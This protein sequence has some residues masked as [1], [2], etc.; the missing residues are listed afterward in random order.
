MPSNPVRLRNV[1]R[2]W[3]PRRWKGFTLIE[4]LVVIAI[5]AV[6][7]ALLLPAVQQARESA[8]RSQCK[9]NLKQ[10][11]LAFHNYHDVSRAFPIGTRFSMNSPNW[12]VGLL[13]YMDQ[14][15]LFNQLNFG[16]PFL[17]S[18]VYPPNS[19]LLST[20]VPLYECPSNAL[21]RRPSYTGEAD[22]TAGMAALDYVG[23][24][25]ASPDPAGRVTGSV[26]GGQTYGDYAR[27]GM[28]VNNESIKVSDCTDGLSATLMVAEQ[29]GQIGATTANGTHDLRSRYYGG[30]AGC[31]CNATGL[32]YNPL[33][34]WPCWSAGSSISLTGTGNLYGTG[35]TVVKYSSNART[36]TG[37][38]QYRYGANT[39]LTSSHTGGVH[40]LLGDGSVRF[41]SDNINLLTLQQLA[42]RDDGGIVGE[43]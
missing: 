4:L 35:I 42:T 9:N 38:A 17:G 26:C 34:V 15:P 19:I 12:R 43:F 37:G 6:L 7:V 31:N 29:S 33:S 41:I 21:P 3:K 20:T 27:T 25:G 23:I 30:W 40:G 16:Q 5:I 32:Q 2:V 22:N 8:R 36:A 39:M 10:L 18:G 28:L 24:S 14:A 13:P 11:G 1:N